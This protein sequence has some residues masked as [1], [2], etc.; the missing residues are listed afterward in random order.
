M[1]FLFFWCTYIN[2][3]DGGKKLHYLYIYILIVSIIHRA[4]QDE[5]VSM[6]GHA[7]GIFLSR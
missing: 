7:L 2:N 3:K 1:L 5:M 6:S 4:T